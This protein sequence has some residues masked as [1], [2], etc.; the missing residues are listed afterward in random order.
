MV[1]TVKSFSLQGSIDVRIVKNI[2]KFQKCLSFLIAFYNKQGI[3][4]TRLA[5]IVSKCDIYSI[6]APEQQY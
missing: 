1:V 2:F 6:E 3:Q 4:G 5:E